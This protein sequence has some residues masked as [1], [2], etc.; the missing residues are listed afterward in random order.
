[1][2]NIAGQ[3]SKRLIFVTYRV[4]NNIIVIEDQEN[5]PEINRK[6]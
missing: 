1:M 3:V 5:G 2:E 6:L 4:H